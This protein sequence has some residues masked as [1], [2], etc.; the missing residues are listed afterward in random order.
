VKLTTGNNTETT[1]TVTP[2]LSLLMLTSYCTGSS[3]VALKF[4][5]RLASR[6]NSWI[7][8]MMM[9]QAGCPVGFW[10]RAS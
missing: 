5:S 1:V 10:S 4:C 3:L 8:M 7:M 6:W 9:M 2:K